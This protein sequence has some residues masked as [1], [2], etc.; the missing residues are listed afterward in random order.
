M[1]R[2]VVVAIVYSCIIMFNK[3]MA[4]E[5]DASNVES[6]PNICE[7]YDHD[8]T[9]RL[10]VAWKHSLDMA[11]EL[12][13]PERAIGWFTGFAARDLGC[14][15]PDDWV[16]TLR[17]CL[18]RKRKNVRGADVP[19]IDSPK[20]KVA[21]TVR[22]EVFNKVV[23][24]SEDI[25]V[26]VDEGTGSALVK[27]GDLECRDISL[28]KDIEP[29]LVYLS[30]SA[31]K[32]KDV[33]EAVVLASSTW[34]DDVYQVGLVDSRT[35]H[36]RWTKCGQAAGE[37]PREKGGQGLLVRNGE[38]LSYIGISIVVCGSS[39]VVFGWSS[40]RAFVEAFNVKDGEVALRFAVRQ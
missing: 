39:V 1:A 22:S 3:S 38:D 29:R 35:K 11:I 28:V 26:R 8:P 19:P 31:F 34:I 30:L 14:I 37:L 24:H 7:L 20:R 33:E 16:S 25:V 2:V 27:C 40:H 21:H 17:G 18:Y 13:Q 9:V 32:S 15:P 5:P 36:M 10:G 12:D 23:A 4:T 6:G